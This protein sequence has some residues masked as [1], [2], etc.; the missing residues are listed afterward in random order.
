MPCA[1][2]VEL[3]SRGRGGGGGGGTTE[4][5]SPGHSVQ[6]EQGVT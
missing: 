6:H 1:I 3:R 5:E 4:R 2:S